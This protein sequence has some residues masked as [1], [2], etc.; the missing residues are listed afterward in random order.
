MNIVH[1]KRIMSDSEREMTVSEIYKCMDRIKELADRCE[2]FRG[3]ECLAIELKKKLDEI[4]CMMPF[5]Y[6]MRKERFILTDRN[7]KRNEQEGRIKIV[8]E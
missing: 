6:Y 8:Q 7:L 4:D 1:L 3:G 2:K 5:V